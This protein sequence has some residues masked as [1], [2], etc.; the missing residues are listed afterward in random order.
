MNTRGDDN[1][2]SLTA[3]PLDPAAAGAWVVL[4]RCGASVVFTGSARDHAPGRTGVS[5]LEYEAY[6]EQVEP[7]LAAIAE[8]ARRTWPD[9]GRVALHHRTGTVRVGEPSVVVAASAPHREEAFAAARWCIDTL[10]ATVPLWKKET[11]DDGEAWGVDA[12]PVAD[13][14]GG[15]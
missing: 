8:E 13:I 3:D 7:R 5:G 1:W 15:R 11:W 14:D 12:Q 6:E 10:K 9:V 4:P 2:V